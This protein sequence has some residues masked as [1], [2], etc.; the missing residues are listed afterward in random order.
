MNPKLLY[1]GEH[2]EYTYKPV[3][4]EPE[5]EDLCM[6]ELDD[7]YF[8]LKKKQEYIAKCGLSSTVAQLAILELEEQKMALRELMHKKLD[9]RLDG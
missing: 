6:A 5:L 8:D 3:K 7:K 4:R 1:Y 2:I 9:E